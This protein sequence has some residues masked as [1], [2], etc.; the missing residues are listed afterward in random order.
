ME[1]VFNVNIDNNDVNADGRHITEH[2]PSFR[3]VRTAS[4]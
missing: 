1:P 2:L 4:F 3:Q